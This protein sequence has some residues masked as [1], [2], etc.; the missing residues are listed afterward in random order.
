MFTASHCFQQK[1]FTKPLE[2]EYLR[3][4]IGRFNLKN[5]KE[6]GAKIALVRQIVLHPD[7]NIEDDRYDADIAIAVLIDGGYQPRPCRHRFCL[8]LGQEQH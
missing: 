5:N 6:I 3:A 1:G 8:G 2:P 7:W 4:L